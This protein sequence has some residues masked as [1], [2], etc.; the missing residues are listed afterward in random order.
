M[1]GAG[2]RGV[3]VGVS[4]ERGVSGGM[5]LYSGLVTLVGPS[6]RGWYAGQ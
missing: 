4:R 5:V 6:G 1:G 3:S 2:E